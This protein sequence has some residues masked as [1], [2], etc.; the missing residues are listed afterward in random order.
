LPWWFKRW[1]LFRKDATLEPLYHFDNPAAVVSSEKVRDSSVEKT[2]EK[3]DPV[4]APT[5]T[6]AAEIMTAE[7][8]EGKK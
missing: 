7:E 3:K 6:A 8:D 4:E 1:V 2:V 5:E